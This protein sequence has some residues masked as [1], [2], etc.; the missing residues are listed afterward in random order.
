MGLILSRIY[1]DYIQTIYNMDY[2]NYVHLKNYKHG[3]HIYNDNDNDNDNHNDNDNDNDR[4]NDNDNDNDNDRDNDCD[5]DN[6]GDNS[7]SNFECDNDDDYCYKLYVYVHPNISFNIKELYINNAL[8]NNQCVDNYL[9]HMKKL[10]TM[11]DNQNNVVDDCLENYCFD[12]GFDLICP[13]DFECSS[14]R[15]YHG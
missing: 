10:N 2:T 12:S 5:N 11:S 8:K 15:N 3:L 13:D 14:P 7:N 4:D 1:D 6:D 9:Y